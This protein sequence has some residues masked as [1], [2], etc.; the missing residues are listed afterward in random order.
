MWDSGSCAVG[1]VAYGEPRHPYWKDVRDSFS[2]RQVALAATDVVDN[3]V[4]NPQDKFGGRV[5]V[6][7]GI[8]EVFVT[9]SPPSAETEIGT[10]EIG[11]RQ[12]TK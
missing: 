5:R 8:F 10:L 9:K 7:R 11:R 4:I 2:P 6:G 12:D 3:C 1:I